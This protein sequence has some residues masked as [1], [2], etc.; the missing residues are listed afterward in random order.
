MN[1]YRRAEKRM[2]TKKKMESNVQEDRTSM[3]GLYIVASA[4]GDK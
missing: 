1:T 2:S 3:D 4:D